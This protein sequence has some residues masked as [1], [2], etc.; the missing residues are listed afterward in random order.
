MANEKGFA[1]FVRATRARTVP[2]VL[3]PVGVGSAL[4]WERA[5]TFAWS[6]FALAIV[7]AAAM[8][9]AGNVVNDYFDERSG[10]DD[11]ARRDYRSVATGSGAIGSGLLP[12]P[13][14]V[15]LAAVLYAVA[16]VCGIVIA[17][18]T[19]A[20]VLLFG[21]A[22]AALAVGYVAPPV[23][24]GYAGR[25]LG[26][27]GIYLAYGV[28]AVSGAYYAQTGRLDAAALGAGAT[29]GFLP[30]L[31]LYHHNFLHWH[32][33]R[34]AKKMTPVASLGPQAGLALGRIILLAYVLAVA[35]ASLLAG[36]WPPGAMAAVLAAAPIFVAQ[37]NAADSPGNETFVRLLGASLGGALLGN[38][39]LATASIVRY[40]L[41]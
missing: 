22:G 28:L 4:A 35:A 13:R 37:T 6:R 38:V 30:T 32:A 27:A 1:L 14:A 17:A 41:R 39:V 24:Y 34:E 20:R 12:G 36:V 26:E 19:D 8:Q 3:G 25:G 5:G 7:G 2:L 15:L 29:V 16:A 18:Q 21:A 11:S 40:L 33:D 23:R 9:L 31:A 10:A